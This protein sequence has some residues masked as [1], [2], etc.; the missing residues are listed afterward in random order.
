MLG[1]HNPTLFVTQLGQGDHSGPSPRVWSRLLGLNPSPNGYGAGTYVGD[2]FC[3][4]QGVTNEASGTTT[5]PTTDAISETTAKIALGGIDGYQVYIDSATTASGIS[6]LAGVAGGV[7]RL[8]PGTTDNHLAI[9]H[10]GDLLAFDDNTDGSRFL[11]IWEA[12]V[13]FPTQVTTGSTAIGLGNTAMCADGGLIVD[14]GS[15]ISSTGAFVGFR[16]IDADPDGIDFIYKKNSSGAEVVLL[17]LAKVITADTWV[18]LGM[19]YDPMAIASKRLSIFVDNTEAATYGTA[20]NMAAATF[21]DGV[22]LG[23]V[24]AAKSDG[25]SVSRSLDVDWWHCYQARVQE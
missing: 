1:I 13:R 16:T 12:R 19:V 25:N 21:P 14:T 2:D 17:D 9:M 7:A 11:T 22:L 24:F 8:T 10:S 6:R 23:S 15:I 18:K 5:Y 20:T 4:F 3:R